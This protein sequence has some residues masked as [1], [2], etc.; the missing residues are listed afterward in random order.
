[1]TEPETVLLHTQQAQL[2]LYAMGYRKV[3]GFLPAEVPNRQQSLQWFADL[4]RKEILRAENGALVLQPPWNRCLRHWGQARAVLRLHTAAP[5]PDCCCYPH[6]HGILV[7]APQPRRP[8]MLRL[9]ELA[10]P[11]LW[12]WLAD[13]YDLPAEEPDLLCQ[14]REGGGDPTAAQ[15]WQEGTPPEKLPGFLFLLE[16]RPLPEGTSRRMAALQHPLYR[17][18]LWQRGTEVVQTP[19]TRAELEQGLQQWLGPEKENRL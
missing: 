18:L 14:Q 5:G 2:L 17:E 9:T 15:A 8:E 7:C 10:Y 19:Y 3:Y 16:W 6:T 13:A 12:D 4:V 1:M 11:Q